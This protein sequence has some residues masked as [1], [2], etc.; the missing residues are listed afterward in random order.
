MDLASFLPFQHFLKSNH[1]HLVSSIIKAFLNLNYIDSCSLCFD[2]L[3]N[4]SHFLLPLRC[5]FIL[6]V[7]GLCGTEGLAHRVVQIVVFFII[8]LE[9]QSLVFIFFEK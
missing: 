1:I 7:P 8:G 3:G 5:I 9:S 2:I 4:L 6:I